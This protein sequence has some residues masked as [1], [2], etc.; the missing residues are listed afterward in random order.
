MIIK[1]FKNEYS[2]LNLLDLRFSTLFCPPPTLRIF[3]FL[4][5]PIFFYLPSVA[6]LK[7]LLPRLY[8]NVYYIFK[9]VRLYL[10]VSGKKELT[11][12][13]SE[14]KY[15]GMAT[16]IRM[17]DEFHIVGGFHVQLRSFCYLFS[18]STFFCVKNEQNYS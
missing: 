7:Q 17:S 12:I 16:L 15:L 18:I 2:F 10:N 13:R 8:L 1:R 11:I 14:G 3:F 9:R 4:E 5:P 6:N